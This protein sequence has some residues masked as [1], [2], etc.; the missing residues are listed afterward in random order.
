MRARAPRL[1]WVNGLAAIAIGVVLNALAR[2]F[3]DTPALLLGLAVPVGMVRCRQPG[4][5]LSAALLLALASQS[6]FTG[7]FCL[8][9]TA[10]AWVLRERR[11]R[12]RLWLAP[13]LAL[14]FAGLVVAQAGNL[15]CWVSGLAVMEL[16]VVLAEV[17]ARMLFEPLALRHGDRPSLHDLLSRRLTVVLVPALFLF[18][19]L[20]VRGYAEERSA[21]LHRNA[22]SANEQMRIAVESHVGGHLRAVAQAADDATASGRRPV[23]AGLRRQ[24]DGFITLLVTDAAGRIVDFSAPSLL[25]ALGEVSDREYFRVPRDTGQAWVSGVFRGRGFGSDVLVAV[26]APYFDVEGRFL[27]VVEGSLSLQRLERL[28]A[29]QASPH[30][31]DFVLRDREGKVVTSSLADLAPLQRALHPALLPGPSAAGLPL[32]AARDRLLV[33]SSMEGLGWRLATLAP[34]APLQRQLLL[35]Q[36]LIGA[37]ALSGL[38]LIHRLSARFAHELA[39]PL[40]QLLRRVRAVDLEHPTTLEPLD[41]EA[42]FAELAQLFADFDVM[43]DRLA[44]LDRRLRGVLEEQARLNR[45]LEQRVRE[46]TEDLREALVKARELAQAKSAFLAN[47]SHE[48]RTPLTSIL[49][50]AELALAADAPPAQREQALRTILRQSEHLLAVVNDVLDANRIESGALRLEIA[51]VVIADLLRELRDLFAARAHERGIVLEVGAEDG[52]PA[53]LMADPL[54]LRQVLINLLGNAVKFTTQGRVELRVARRLG[55]IVFAVRDT[56]TGIP[57]AIRPRLFQP[58]SQADASTTRRFGGS[59]LGLFISRNLCEA[60]GGRLGFHSRPGRGSRFFAVFPP[61]LACGAGRTQASAEGL[62]T[63]PRLGGRVLI[64]EDVGDLRQLI[65]ILVER[66]GAEVIGCGDGSEAVAL[67][68]RWHPD[69]VLMDMHMPVMD[70]VEAT[71]TLRERGFTRPIVALTADVLAEDRRRF[72]DAGCDEVLHK[73]VRREALH[74]LLRRFLPPASDPTGEV[75]GGQAPLEQLRLRYAR[76]LEELGAE[77]E[78]LFERGE[79]QALLQRLH[80][81]KGSAG[82]FGFAEV[83]AAAAELEAVL[84][85][86]S[87]PPGA[88]QQA[89]DRLVAALR[90]ACATAGAGPG[91]G[92]G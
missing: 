91:P 28:L 41:L 73:P 70:G 18:L 46:R 31:L 85:A 34:M 57:D 88:E 72:L 14:P 83:S 68:Q 87:P 27:G 26:S 15:A 47:M 38:I 25:G 40:Q 13:L 60:M 59:G 61:G 80:T 6:P 43:L 4:W 52:L 71:H 22:F 76:R 62:E 3:P 12:T 69:L 23:L 77:I 35:A 66:T 36:L 33:D 92:V 63:P 54:R 58:F 49:G 2:P 50:Y 90:E 17:A 75:R 29:R 79:V 67:A 9:V 82:T 51:P 84:R 37:A 24:H 42:P 56:G 65:A 21:T 19:M 7:L 64:A 89:H 53:A 55:A 20:A 30:E 5:A 10:I 45:E 81:L 1:R 48:L 74:A 8:A 32:N 16:S 39:A 86:T 44:E 78:A 11:T